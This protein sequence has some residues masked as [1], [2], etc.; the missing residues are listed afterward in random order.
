MPFWPNVAY[1]ASHYLLVKDVGVLLLHLI[2]RN[3]RFNVPCCSEHSICK[4]SEKMPS[5]PFRRDDIKFECKGCKE[6]FVWIRGN[7]EWELIL[8]GALHINVLFYFLVKGTIIA[9]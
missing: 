1:Y 9:R 5:K 2:I 3:E 7:F 6:R 4:R 8:W